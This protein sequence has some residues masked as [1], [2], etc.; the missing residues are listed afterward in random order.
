MI[1]MFVK[2]LYVAWRTIEGLEVRKP[3][4]EEYLG[5]VHNK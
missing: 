5:K 4:Q 1:K 3:Y 2:D